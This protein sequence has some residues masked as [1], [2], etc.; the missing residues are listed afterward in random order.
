MVFIFKEAILKLHLP[1]R[2]LAPSLK[3]LPTIF[4]TFDPTQNDLRLDKLHFLSIVPS[5]LNAHRFPSFL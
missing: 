3:R 4:L 5:S 2:R 1:K